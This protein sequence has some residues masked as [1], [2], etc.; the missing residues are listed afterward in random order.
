MS[1]NE[2]QCNYGKCWTACWR[3]KRLL[4]RKALL[5]LQ[6]R[7]KQCHP[8]FYEQTQL[9]VK[10]LLL[11]LLIASFIFISIK[12][13]FRSFYSVKIFWVI[14]RALIKITLFRYQSK[15]SL[16]KGSELTVL[17]RSGNLSLRFRHPFEEALPSDKD[18]RNEIKV[19]ID[20][21]NRLAFF[22]G[23]LGSSIKF[24]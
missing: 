5:N 17:R 23:Y 12:T 15:V 8:W 14:L 19:E 3:R 18:N 4:T 2:K 11:V 7:R 20:N 24:E 1:L 6:I 9:T 21:T 13:V 10:N 16:M 22:I